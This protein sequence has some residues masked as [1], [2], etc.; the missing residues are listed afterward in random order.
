MLYWA[1]QMGIHTNP[2]SSHPS[3]R[4]YLGQIR[5]A[6]DTEWRSSTR[7]LTKEE[8]RK[9]LQPSLEN[10]GIVAVR[11]VVAFVYYNTIAREDTEKVSSVSWYWQRR[12]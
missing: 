10:P 4:Y 9:Y 8:V 3:R 11:I 7:A 5:W 1:K 12:V 2:P 6:D